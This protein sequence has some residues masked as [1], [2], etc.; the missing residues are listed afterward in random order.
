M[1][2]ARLADAERPLMV[3]MIENVY[4]P[5]ACSWLGLTTRAGCTLP[6]VVMVVSDRSMDTVAVVS[7]PLTDHSNVRALF[8]WPS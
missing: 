2:T 1:V 4:L 3:A 5:P 8:T 6:V 7:T